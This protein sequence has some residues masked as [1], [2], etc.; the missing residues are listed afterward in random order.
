[1]PPQILTESA[2][3]PRAENSGYS[4]LGKQ[5]STPF[6]CS[7]YAFEGDG[8]LETRVCAPGI[9]RIPSGTGVARRRVDLCNLTHF[10]P[11]SA[12]KFDTPREVDVE[13]CISWMRLEYPLPRI[14]ANG[15]TNKCRSRCEYSRVKP[16][17]AR[18]I[19]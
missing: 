11:E 6:H 17:L 1:M 3:L 13:F 9:A 2:F 4:S 8:C 12:R 16:E 15:A 19:D 18:S 7:R 14:F 10:S 5:G